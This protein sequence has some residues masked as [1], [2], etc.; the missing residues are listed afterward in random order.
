MYLFTRRQVQNEDRSAGSETTLYRWS[1]GDL[2]MRRLFNIEGD[3]VCCIDKQCVPS[4]IE[5]LNK[6]AEKKKVILTGKALY[7]FDVAIFVLEIYTHLQI[8]VMSG[9][10]TL[11]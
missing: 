3:T 9:I 2:S 8:K 11:I 5:F 4:Q 6:K 1:T 10:V 7:L